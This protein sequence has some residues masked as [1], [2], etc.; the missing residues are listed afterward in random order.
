MPVCVA[1]HG[2]PLKPGFVYLSPSERNLRVTPSH[3][4]QLQQS[5][6]NSLYHPNCD[7]LLTSV[8]NVYG[9]E[10]IGVILTGMGRDGVSGMRAIHLSGGCTFAQNEASSVIYGMNQ[11][12]VSAGVIQHVVS[13][14][15]L[16]ARLIRETRGQRLSTWTKSL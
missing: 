7:A 1:Q 8:A 5:P 15:E 6:D 9:P 2:E 14:D 13:L 12:A 10:A 16:P 3:R 4:L 11:E